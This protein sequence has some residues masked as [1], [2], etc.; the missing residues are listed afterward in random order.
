MV[1][2]KQVLAFVLTWGILHVTSPT[3]PEAWASVVI[4]P[5]MVAMQEAAAGQFVAGTD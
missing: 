5:P 1:R 3:S 4:H 2:L